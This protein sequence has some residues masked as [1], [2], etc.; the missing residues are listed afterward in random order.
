MIMRVKG[1]IHM[2]SKVALF[3]TSPNGSSH[4]KIIGS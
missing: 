2:T 4:L 3:G 1:A